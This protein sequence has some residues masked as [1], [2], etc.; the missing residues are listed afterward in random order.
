MSVPRPRPRPAAVLLAAML[1]GLLAVPTPA[2]ADPGAVERARAEAARIQAEVDRLQV[3]AEV[4]AE[5]YEATEEHLQA[6]LRSALAHQRALDDQEL[7]VETA[8]VGL[9]EQVRG[10]YEVGPLVSAELL[11]LADDPHELALAVHVAGTSLTTGVHAVDQA[12]QAQARDQALVAELRARQ[13]EVLALRQRQGAQRAAIEQALAQQRELLGSAERHVRELVAAARAR[14]EAARRALV[15]AAATRARTLGLEGF[16]TAPPPTQAAGMAVHAALGQLGKPYRWGATGPGEFDCSGLTSWAYQQAGVD[17]PRTSRAQWSAGSHVAVAALLPG[18]LVFF[19]TDPRNP[20]TIHHVGMY[21]GQGLMVN[22]PYTGAVVRV[23]PVR[24][25]D[26]VGA[27]R[28]A[29]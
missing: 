3:R 9:D 11:L 1:A 4:T 29:S 23:E 27:T 20:G 8:Q 28:P 16:A 19:G 18:D 7:A 14:E 17:L 6:A 15:A 13:A 26:Y 2:A 12:T 22:A 10:I 21:V 24:P 25:D 5:A